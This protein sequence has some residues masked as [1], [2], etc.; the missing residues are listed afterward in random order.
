MA[1][2][3]VVARNSFEA[4]GETSLDSWECLVA[5]K[6]SV[7]QLG[8]LL[9]TCSKSELGMSPFKAANKTSYDSSSCTGEGAL[10]CA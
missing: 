10:D 7:L 8:K 1:D 5:M 3:F 2:R 9:R 4:T 6:G